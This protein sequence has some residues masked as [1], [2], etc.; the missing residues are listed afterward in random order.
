MYRRKTKNYL[1]TSFVLNTLESIVLE[2][3]TGYLNIFKSIYYN[4]VS[5]RLKHNMQ[6]FFCRYSCILNVIESK[7]VYRYLFTIENIWNLIRLSR[8]GVRCKIPLIE[9]IMCNILL[10][11]DK[12]VRESPKCSL[13]NA[14]KIMTYTYEYIQNKK[15]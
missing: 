15:L 12:S 6:L 10:R 4:T 11:R 14:G 8:I 3:A 13:K 7:W 2:N 9:I 1:N 5:R